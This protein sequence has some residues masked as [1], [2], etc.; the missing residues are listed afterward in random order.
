[1]TVGGVEKCCWLSV[2]FV[3][4]A[5]YLRIRLYWLEEEADGRFREE[6]ADADRERT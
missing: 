1:M 3:F 6:Q 5:G 4:I 2:L